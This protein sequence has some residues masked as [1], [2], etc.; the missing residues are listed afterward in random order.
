MDMVIG[1]FR[2]FYVQLPGNADLLDNF[3][4][5]LQTAYR[6]SDMLQIPGDPPNVAGW[7]AYY[8]EPA[9]HELWINT[10]TLPKRVAFS[11]IMMTSGFTRDGIKIV[12]DPV[13]YTEALDT[14]ES[15]EQLID[16]A[17]RLHYRIDVSQEFRDFLMNILLSGQS[18]PSYWTEAWLNY[19]ANPGN[20]TNYNA[21]FTRLQSFYK[22]IIDQ[23]EHQ[24]S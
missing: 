11:D 18:D 6:M 23:P 2:C 22:Y 12:I 16:Q 17:L 7:S 3:F 14:P 15:P 24:L 13:S 9:F 4:I 21:V 8:Q 1:L 19:T 10:D 5:S 20:Q